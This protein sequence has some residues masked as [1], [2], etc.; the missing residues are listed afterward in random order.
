MA[1]FTHPRPVCMCMCVCNTT[2]KCIDS[3]IIGISQTCSNN[4]IS[5][6]VSYMLT[7]R[8]VTN[9]FPFHTHKMCSWYIFD[10]KS[11]SQYRNP[12]N[13]LA[14]YDGT[15]QEIINQCGGKVDMVVAGAGTGGVIAGIGRK[16]KE[17]SPKTKVGME[18]DNSIN[19]VG[20]E[21]GGKGINNDIAM[22]KLLL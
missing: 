6:T 19:R 17:L 18:W 22:H 16:F 15:A 13:P 11:S 3:D 4:V 7:K 9:F 12:G 20:I 5:M 10:S 1:E 14:H 8:Y 21:W 2:S